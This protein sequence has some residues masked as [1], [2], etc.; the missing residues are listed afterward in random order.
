MTR[1]VVDCGVENMQVLNTV[2]APHHPTTPTRQIGLS[3]TSSSSPSS[4]W[5]CCFDPVEEIQNALQ[6]VLDTLR[7]QVF[8]GAFQVWQEHWE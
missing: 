8:L 5:S 4:S 6:M 3:V 2:V 7:E 1:T